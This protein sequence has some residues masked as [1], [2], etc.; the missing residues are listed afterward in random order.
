MIFKKSVCF[1][2]IDDV[3]KNANIISSH[4]IYKIKISDDAS[5]KLKAR[6]APHG[7]EDSF[8]FDLKSDC[9]MCSPCGMRIIL[10]LS[11]LY[12]WSL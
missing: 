9:A 2:K 6:I 12:K 4:V 3:P 8:K 11:S 1:I 10:S 5:L 7:N